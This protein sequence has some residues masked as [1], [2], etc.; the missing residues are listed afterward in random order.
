MQQGCA[1]G[2]GAVSTHTR[3][4]ASVFRAL[5]MRNADDWH[6]GRFI[7]LCGCLLSHTCTHIFRLRPFCFVDTASVIYRSNYNVV[8]FAPMGIGEGL[9][10]TVVIYGMWF[11]R[12]YISFQKKSRLLICLQREKSLH[13]EVVV[14]KREKS[15]QRKQIEALSILVNEIRMKT[16]IAA[17]LKKQ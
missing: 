7:C 9:S 3:A 1:N 5:L 2:A 6:D 4:F 8:Y 10:A 15:V 16:A 11:T 17:D 12:I 14:L 13:Q